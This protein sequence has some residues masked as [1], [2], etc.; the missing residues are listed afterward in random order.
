[1]SVNHEEFEAQVVSLAALGDPIRRRLYEYVVNEPLPVSRDQAAENVAVARHVA[2]FHL[3]KLEDEGLLDVEFN[4]PSG[5]RGPGAGRPTKFYRRSLREIAVTLP[6]R[7]YDFASRLLAR[8]IT[9]STQEGI[10]VADALRE[11]ANSFGQTLAVEMRSEI[12]NRPS[13]Q[14]MAEA[15]GQVLSERGY[16]PRGNANGMTLANCPF[17]GLAQE[18]TALA[19]GMNKDFIQGLLKGLP[20]QLQVILDPELGRCCVRLVKP[21]SHSNV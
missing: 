17:H 6:E 4:R 14:K 16:E 3:D 18:Y 2:K 15:I 1:M 8:A 10:P 11:S 20:T 5:R 13:Q 7:H 9:V 19:C 12:G 21:D